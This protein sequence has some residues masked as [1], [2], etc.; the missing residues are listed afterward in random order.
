MGTCKKTIFLTHIRYADAV[1]VSGLL[2]HKQFKLQTILS[3]AP[4]LQGLTG[5]EFVLLALT[6]AW[7]FPPEEKPGPT[8]PE[9]TCSTPDK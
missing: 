6:K 9:N 3:G 4:D 8:Y 2:Y 5:L 7:I 1:S